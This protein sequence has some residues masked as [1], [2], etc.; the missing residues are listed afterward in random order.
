[1]SPTHPAALLA[2]ELLSDCDI[3]RTRRGGPGGQHRNKTESAIVVTHLPTGIVAQAGERRSQHQNRAVAIERLRLKLAVEIRNK[4]SEDQRPTGKW[5]GRVRGSKIS[6][7]PSHHDF[8]ALLAEALDYV[9]SVQ[10]DIPAAAKRLAVSN[11]QLI[12]LL[13]LHPPAI[14]RLNQNRLD[15]GLPKLN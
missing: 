12:K 10:L 11:S 14:T 4:V 13:K 8:P 2:D 1:M 7:N 6:V 5:M 15:L 3:K 9:A